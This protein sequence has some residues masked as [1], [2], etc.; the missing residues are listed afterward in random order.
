MPYGEIYIIRSKETPDVYY[1]STKQ[2]I[3]VRLNNHKQLYKKY[4]KDKIGYCRSYDILKYSDAYIESVEIVEYENKKQLLER[5]AFYIK[6][7]PCVNIS[8]PNQTQKEY[9]QAHKEELKEKR[10][11]YVAKNKDKIRG[12]FKE[13]ADKNKEKRKAYMKE[14]NEKNQDKLKKYQEDR[15]NK[16]SE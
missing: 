3:E 9:R 1:G 15:K 8:I 12:D 14:W 4:L 7:N 16:I 11:V 13:W 6:N 5:E 10:K 2:H